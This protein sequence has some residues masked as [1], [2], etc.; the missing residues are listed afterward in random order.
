MESHPTVVSWEQAKQLIS[1]GRIRKVHGPS[2]LI[3]YLDDKSAVVIEG[4][5][6]DAV[7]YIWKHAPNGKEIEATMELD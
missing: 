5:P 4:A 3:A 7:A 6:V 2:P 1:Q